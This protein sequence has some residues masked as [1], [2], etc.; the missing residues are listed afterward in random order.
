MLRRGADPQAR[1]LPRL[2][3]DLR[4]RPPP[5]ATRHGG[6]SRISLVDSRTGALIPAA[7]DGAVL[8]TSADAGWRGITVELHRMGPTEMP[9]HAVQGH[10]LLIHAG[11][12]IEFEWR[13]GG[14]GGWRRTLL[15]PGD[16]C[17]QT[18]GEPNAPRWHRDFEFLAVALDPVFVARLVREDLDAGAVAFCE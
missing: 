8:L 14:G 7:P 17:L 1:R 18:H 15:N 12:P 16:F 11:R 10:R 3:A 13:A 6:E 9:E 5:S 4:G 2:G